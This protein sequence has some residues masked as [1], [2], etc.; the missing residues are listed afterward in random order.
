VK[1]RISPSILN[2]DFANLQTEIMSVAS[3]DMLHVDVMDGHFV[4]NLTIGLPVVGRIQEISPIPLDVHLM[5]ENPDHWAVKYAQ[6]GAESVTFHA[7]A[8]SDIKKTIDSIRAAGSRVGL[9]I[10]PATKVEDF[11]HFLE[12]LDMIL[13]MTVEPGFGGQPL[14]REVLPKVTSC[15]TFIAEQGLSTSIQVDGG[16]T[17]GNI[18]DVARAGADCFVAGSAIFKDAFREEQISSLRNLA[19]NL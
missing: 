5:I 2:A 6:L 8:A 3:A 9:A 15:R 12:F 17:S 1:V 4:P 11:F 13:I 14:I 16:I 19:S 7:E 18:Q 10:K